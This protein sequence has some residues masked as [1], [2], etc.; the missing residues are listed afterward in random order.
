MMDLSKEFRAVRAVGTPI[1]AIK[2]G[3]QPETIRALLGVIGNDVPAL[4]WDVVSGLKPLTK[5]GEIALQKALSDTPP[6]ATADPVAALEVIARLPERSAI[7]MINAHR[8]AGDARVSTGIGSLREPFKANG[9]TAVLLGP[10]FDFPAELLPDIILLSDPL[11]GDGELERIVEFVYEQAEANSPGKVEKMT[12]E[13]KAAAVA[14][15]RGLSTFG[16]EQQAFL[17]LRRSN[18]G[19]KVALDMASLWSRKIEAVNAIPGLQMEYGKRQDS[20]VRG[21]TALRSMLDRLF[22]EENPERPGAILHIDEID[23]ALAGFGRQGA[24]DSSGV[25]QDQ[26]GQILQT[27][28]ERG[29]DGIIPVG[30]PGT[31]KTMVSKTAASLYGV[32]YVRL[33]LGALKGSLVGES[34][35]KIRTAL[36]VIDR[37][38]AGRVFVFATCNRL[39]SLPPELKRRFTGGI[40]YFDLPD[41]DD[42][43]AL[44][45]LY[46][47]Q[48]E[49]PES[50][51]KA[52]LSWSDGWT[53]A[54]I[55]NACRAVRRLRIPLIE[56]RDLIVPASESAK[57]DIERLRSLA[58]GR[59]L[60]AARGG[61]YSGQPSI[62]S[63]STA[64]PKRRIE[65]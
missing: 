13:M 36:E 2:T 65:V 59:F 19:G 51:I 8:F 31:G 47:K 49:V 32:P 53:G 17:S 10:S 34:E 39:D 26:V 56:T 24:G 9:A 44:W 35:Q 20:G 4:R 27:M 21:L 7:F 16:A 57:D 33:D 28:E 25:T 62:P 41:A 43:E 64:S 1:I 11:P 38:A 22:G 12:T 18:G 37:M 46:G 3:N 42:R 54:E 30:P 23:K 58:S 63:T 45:T 14:A 40:W 48:Y 61:K 6:E 52:A 5:P 55:R 15:L 50:D 60:D 29:W